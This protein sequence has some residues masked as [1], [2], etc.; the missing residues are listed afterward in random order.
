MTTK[1]PGQLRSVLGLTASISTPYEKGGAANTTSK[2][3]L[4]FPGKRSENYWLNYTPVSWNGWTRTTRFRSIAKVSGIGS[5]PAKTVSISGRDSCYTTP[6]RPLKEYIKI[7][8]K[9]VGCGMRL[10]TTMDGKV[11]M[12]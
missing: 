10:A 12:L 7:V 11:G 9:V 5:N 1:W 6:N 8:A 3:S 4:G 2:P